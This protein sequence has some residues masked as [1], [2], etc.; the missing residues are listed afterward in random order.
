MD[1]ISAQNAALRSR[2]IGA[3]A[4]VFV[5]DAVSDVADLLRW[6]DGDEAAGSLM[7]RSDFADHPEQGRESV[8]AAIQDAEDVQVARGGS[9]VRDAFMLFLTAVYRGHRFDRPGC[10]ERFLEPPDIAAVFRVAA[11]SEQRRALAA[12]TLP[13]VIASVRD[14]RTPRAIAEGIRAFACGDPEIETAM[15]EYAVAA[16]EAVVLGRVPE[17]VMR[18]APA[19]LVSTADRGG[20]ATVSSPFDRRG[21][22]LDSGIVCASARVFAEA[23]GQRVDRCRVDRMPSALSESIAHRVVGSAI[24]CSG[25][26][27]VA[28]SLAA[29]TL[30]TAALPGALVSLLPVRE[31]DDPLWLA[32]FAADQILGPEYWSAIPGLGASD[33]ALVPHPDDPGVAFTRS[34]GLVAGLADE[35]D[36]ILILASVPGAL[37]HKV[38]GKAMVVPWDFAEGRETEVAEGSISLDFRDGAGYGAVASEWRGAQRVADLVAEYRQRGLSVAVD[39]GDAGARAYAVAVHCRRERERREDWPEML[40]PEILVGEVGEPDPGYRERRLRDALLPL[41]PQLADDY[42]GYRRWAH[43]EL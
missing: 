10:A 26:P 42:E 43:E 24:A 36:V 2:A 3:L 29:G 6:V 21:E 18:V 14:G 35:C 40:S 41:Y 16:Y 1:Q 20:C 32:G 5:G 15:D 37:P 19:E 34:A 25:M 33:P 38:H 39:V 27:G 22:A 11:E 12:L 17:V 31:D 23:L 7:G 30:G 9:A 8:R 13:L 4:G 28:L